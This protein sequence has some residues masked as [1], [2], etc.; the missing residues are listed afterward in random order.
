MRHISSSHY[1][2]SVGICFKH[3]VW[4]SLPPLRS[5]SHGRCWYY[6]GPLLLSNERRPARVHRVAQ[7]PF[8]DDVDARSLESLRLEGRRELHQLGRTHRL[9][10]RRAAQQ[11]RAALQLLAVAPVAT[12]LLAE[13]VTF[14]DEATLG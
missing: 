2:N 14:A 7:L 12:S 10:E 13:A 1:C 11:A 6:R 5:L 8:D 3:F 9:E 4:P